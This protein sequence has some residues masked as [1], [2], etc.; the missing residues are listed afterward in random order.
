MGGSQGVQAT[1]YF[2]PCQ[3]LATLG[4]RIT[5]FALWDVGYSVE[6]FEGES[7]AQRQS[8]KEDFEPVSEQYFGKMTWRGEQ[9]Q[10]WRQ[11]KCGHIAAVIENDFCARRECFVGVHRC[12]RCNH[13]EAVVLVFA[14]LVAQRWSL[15]GIDAK[16]TRS[17]GTAVEGFVIHPGPPHHDDGF[18]VLYPSRA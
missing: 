7:K 8:G 5:H 18:G 17:A 14:F 2:V 12:S 11:V 13:T 3:R 4:S 16:P 10:W 9:Q 1:P 6:I 15:V